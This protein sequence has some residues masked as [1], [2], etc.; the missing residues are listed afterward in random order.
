MACDNGSLDI[1]VQDNGKGFDSKT[2]MANG[3]CSMDTQDGLRNMTKR[4]TDVGGRCVIESA[5]GS[6]TTIRFILPLKTDEKEMLYDN[7]FHS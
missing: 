6:G 5:V 7:G 3:S 4:I 2:K 1:C